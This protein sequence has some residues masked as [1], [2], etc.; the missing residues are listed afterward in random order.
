MI[1]RAG[2]AAGAV[3]TIRE[4]CGAEDFAG[5]SS[6]ALSPFAVIDLDRRI[7]LVQSGV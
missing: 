7:V 6:M 2:S 4:E 5:C 3:R 1:R